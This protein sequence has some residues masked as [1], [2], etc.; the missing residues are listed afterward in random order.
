M[1]AELM[2]MGILS[3]EPIRNTMYACRPEAL[4]AW[5]S[6]HGRSGGSCR[7]P[8]MDKGKTGNMLS[9]VHQVR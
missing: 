1:E 5:D 7:A 8:E 9:D 4:F 6:R 3:N 2:Q